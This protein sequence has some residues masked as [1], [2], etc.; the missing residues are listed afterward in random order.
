MKCMHLGE[1]TEDKPTQ[2]DKPSNLGVKSREQANS[3]RQDLQSWCVKTTIIN[4]FSKISAG[5][6]PGRRLG[7]CFLG[8]GDKTC[9]WTQKDRYSRGTDPGRWLFK[10][11]RSLMYLLARLSGGSNEV[12]VV[13][14]VANHFWIF[15]IFRNDGNGQFDRDRLTTMVKH[16]GVG[17]N[18]NETCC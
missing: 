17:E 3:S 2:R 15:A 11:S 14:R 7:L 13:H 9:P 10:L 16:V 6:I 5:P 8:P 4:S 1:K 18:L 12:R